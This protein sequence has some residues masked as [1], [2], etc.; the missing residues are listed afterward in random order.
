MPLWSGP[1]LAPRYVARPTNIKP[2]DLGFEFVTD[3]L[4][5]ARTYAAA[6]PDEIALAPPATTAIL[7]IGSLDWNQLVKSSICIA[8]QLTATGEET[9][10]QFEPSG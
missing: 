2:L 8:Q 10:Y 5:K 6:I 9:S 1:H 7:A 3:T 4:S